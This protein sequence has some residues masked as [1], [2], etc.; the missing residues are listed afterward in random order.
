M[1]LE[2]GLGHPLVH[3]PEGQDRSIGDVWEAGTVELRGSATHTTATGRV[4]RTYQ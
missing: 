3:G 4:S 1:A 2:D